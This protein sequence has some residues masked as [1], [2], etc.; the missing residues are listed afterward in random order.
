MLLPKAFAGNK[1]IVKLTNISRD[2]EVWGDNALVNGQVFE[3]VLIPQRVEDDREKPRL[4]SGWCF[5]YKVKTP[6]GRTIY[7]SYH[8]E[9]CPVLKE[10]NSS[11]QNVGFG[12]WRSGFRCE[13]IALLT[14][15]MILY[16]QQME[17]QQLCCVLWWHVMDVYSHPTIITF[18]SSPH[19]SF[20]QEPPV[21]RFQHALLKGFTLSVGLHSRCKDGTCGQAWTKQCTA[22]LWPQRLV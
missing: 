19:Y 4:P 13:C 8:I 16:N 11:G 12:I 20:W 22:S 10:K 14:Y 15:C 9:L 6:P 21:L 7:S 5:Y 17:P 2:K 1:R 3:S 18:T